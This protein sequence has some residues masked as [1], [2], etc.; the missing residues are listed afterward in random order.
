MRST[1]THLKF[2]VALLVSLG[3]AIT[4]YQIF[5]IGIPVTEDATDNLWTVD[6][7]VEFQAQS[8][9]RSRSTCLYRR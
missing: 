7:K 1:N 6:A 3:L 9:N 8:A 5:V 2:M 4:A